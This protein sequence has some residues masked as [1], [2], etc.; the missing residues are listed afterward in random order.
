MVVRC[1]AVVE[2]SHLGGWVWYCSVVAF[3]L[4]RS[5]LRSFWVW[6]NVLVRFFPD[7]R[8]VHVCVRTTVVH[9]SVCWWPSSLGSRQGSDCGYT[10][11]RELQR[12]VSLY[13]P[14]LGCRPCSFRQQHLSRAHSLHVEGFW[15]VSLQTGVLR[16][17]F[18]PCC[19][20]HAGAFLLPLLEVV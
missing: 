2:R 13:P 4:G 14:S 9:C 15:C 8:C 11:R 5:W 3:G 6:M 17:A 7:C 19:C 18:R 20:I 1:Q 10:S 12:M 16:H